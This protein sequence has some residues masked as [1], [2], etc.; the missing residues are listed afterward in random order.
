[1]NIP[2]IVSGIYGMN[3]PGIPFMDNWWFP[4]A[5]TV[6]GMIVTWWILKRKDMI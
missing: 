4:F 5:L 2:T 1:M 6:F 3:N